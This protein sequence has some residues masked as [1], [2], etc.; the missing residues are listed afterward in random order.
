VSYI[1]LMGFLLGLRHALD[2]DHVA[3]VA[4]LAS[5]T[6]SARET[7]RVGMAWGVGHALTLLTV[8]L[9][10]LAL[11]VGFSDSLATG[12]EF[13]VGIMLV[14]LGADVIRRVIRDRVHAHGHSHDRRGKHLHV[15]SH[16]DDRNHAAASHDHAHASG[17]TGRA[18]AV[19]LMHG[20]AGSAA[21]LV[22]SIVNT[23]DFTIG[24]IYVALFGIGSMLGMAA[25]SVTIA[26]P[27]CL[28]VRFLTWGYN[29]IHAA[30]GAG[31]AALGVLVIS[32]KAPAAMALIGLG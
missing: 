16:A 28:G 15:H 25:L 7:V 11:G 27:L 17:L 8:C 5:R 6:R 12:L 29:G 23:A 24:L 19:G 30:I 13:L 2:A 31:T 22:V 26:L 9:F 21:L 32:D 4:T 10:V 14:L 1:F 20:L 18:M 3:A